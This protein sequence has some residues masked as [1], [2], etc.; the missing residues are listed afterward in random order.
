MNL[1]HKAIRNGQNANGNTSHGYTNYTRD[2]PG[3]YIRRD[4]GI[5]GGMTMATEGNNVANIGSNSRPTRRES[6]QPKDETISSPPYVYLTK[7]AITS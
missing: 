4:N 5:N 6:T 1:I 2:F 7:A 3:K